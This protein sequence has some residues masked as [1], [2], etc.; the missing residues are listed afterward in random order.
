MLGPAGA[1]DLGR[2]RDFGALRPGGGRLMW[3]SRPTRGDRLFIDA[4]F[5][6][7]DSSAFASAST[8]ME[9]R[10]ALAAHGMTVASL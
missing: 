10:M 6:L 9:R 4:E 3:F 1:S 8:D 7:D 5:T 2:Y